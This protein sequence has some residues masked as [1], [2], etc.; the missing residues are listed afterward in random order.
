MLRVLTVVGLFY[1]KFYRE[2]CQIALLPADLNL[3]SLMKIKIKVEIRLLAQTAS[4]STNETATH[5]QLAIIDV[6]DRLIGTGY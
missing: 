2:F 1:Q 6:L 3:V 4:R 5:E